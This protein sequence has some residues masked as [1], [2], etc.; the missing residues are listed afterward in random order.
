M[1]RHESE[2]QLSSAS[3]VLEQLQQPPSL[4]LISIAETLAPKDNNS[5]SADKRTSTISDDSE[6]NGDTHPAALQADLLHYKELFGKLRFS[7]VEQVTKEKFLR[8]ITADPPS[9]VEATEN[10]AK[11]KEI[12]ALK[13]TLKERKVEIAE[14][15]LQLEAKGRDLSLRYEG[16]QLKTQQLASLP[17]EIQGLE[18]N[19][20]TLKK[21]QVPPSQNPELALPLPETARLV[22]QRE[23]ELAA[24]NAQLAQ[25][26]SSIPNRTR[27]LEK[28]ERE[29]KPLETQKQGTVAAAKEARRR[30]E[31]GGGIGDELEERG[32]W[33]RA[34]ESALKKMLEV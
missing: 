23:T 26:Q 27:E 2:S 6:Q 20:E 24:L 33:L 32:R 4:K 29:L 16:V 1:M 10:E 25:L 8:G 9:L 19:I 30:R 18:A 13:A 22:E 14:L 3:A 12:L 21:E 31:D 5:Q 17:A 34:S 15:L 7:Y 11:E 28:L